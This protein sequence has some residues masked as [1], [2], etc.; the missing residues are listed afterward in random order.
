[1]GDSFSLNQNGD[2]LSMARI[3]GEGSG[4]S[5]KQPENEGRSLLYKQGKQ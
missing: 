4:E 5:G 3:I 2:R 1:M